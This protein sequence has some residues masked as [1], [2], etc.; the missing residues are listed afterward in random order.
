MN[1]VPGSSNTLAIIVSGAEREHV[2]ASTH[3]PRLGLGHRLGTRPRLL[4]IEKNKPKLPLPGSIPSLHKALLLLGGHVFRLRDNTARLILNEVAL[5][6]SP[7]CFERSPVP[8]LGAGPN[9]HFETFSFNNVFA[10]GAFSET[11][12]Y[13][14]T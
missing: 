7:R 5:G 6:K 11:S 14:I 13:K 9:Q 1:G 10:V 4:T 8:N 2:I 3:L 12:H